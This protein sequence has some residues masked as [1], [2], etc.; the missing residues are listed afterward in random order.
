MPGATPTEATEPRRRQP[1]CG[2]A[3]CGPHPSGSSRPTRRL[4]SG[5]GAFQ[6]P[7]PRVELWEPPPV[8]GVRPEFW[9]GPL[10]LCS[11]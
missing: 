10:S 9:I 11:H 1:A 6:G 7:R 8:G 2:A 3:R 5:P 4:P